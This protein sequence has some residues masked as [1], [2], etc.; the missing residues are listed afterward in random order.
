MS[1]FGALQGK[2]RLARFDMGEDDQNVFIHASVSMLDPDSAEQ[3]K[4]LINGLKALV[5][6]SQARNA[7]LVDPLD[8]QIKDNDVL[9]N[10]TWPTAKV[11]ELVQ[12]MKSSRHHDT[13]KLYS[14]P[15]AATP[16]Q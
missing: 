12:L 13:A 6:L 1:M 9:L 5:A 7:P 8:I 3:L 2:A 4:N 11:A 14:A 15:P 16:A 10:W